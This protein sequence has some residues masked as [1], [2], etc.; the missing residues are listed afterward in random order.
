VSPLLQTECGNGAAELRFNGADIFVSRDEIRCSLGYGRNRM[1]EHFEEVLSTVMARLPE[2]CD[3]RG[4]Y[5]ICD[6]A[7]EK[8][9]CDGLLVGEQYFT[10]D[11]I[12]AAQLRRAGKAVIF[13]CTIGPG[14]EAWSRKMFAEG[15]AVAG[16]FIDTVA[17]HTVE[18]VA[19]IL[20]DHI[21][22]VAAGRGLSITNRFS[23]GYCGWPVAEQQRLFSFFPA[24]FCGIT[25]TG[26]SLMLPIKSI[27]GIIGMG[28]DV[29]RDP[30]FCDKCGMDHC[31]YHL[32]NQTQKERRQ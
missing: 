17:S 28:T 19:G 12:I 31:T 25:L 22:S 32:Y 5:V 10:T 9:R 1:D 8:D 3:A 21:G 26:S 2:L 24:G 18:S 29:S 6:A 23:P 4:G 30:Y 15:D 13:A 7:R 27:S 20:H 11:R 16:H 14:M